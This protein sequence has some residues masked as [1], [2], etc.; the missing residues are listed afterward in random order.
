MDRQ[1]PSKTQPHGSVPKGRARGRSQGFRGLLRFQQPE[2]GQGPPSSS[3]PLSPVSGL[4]PQV[5]AWGLGSPRSEAPPSQVGFPAPQAAPPPGRAW[6]LG[7][8]LS[9]TAPRQMGPPATQTTAPQG[10][11]WG[12][13]SPRTEAAPSQIGAPPTQI[14]APPGRAWG[15]GPQ[16]SETASRQ[17]GAPPTQTTIPQRPAGAAQTTPTLAPSA[18]TTSSGQPPQSISEST[19]SGSSSSGREIETFRSRPAELENKKGTSGKPVNLVANYYAV[20]AKGADRF[21]LYQ[22]HVSFEPNSE[23]QRARNLALRNWCNSL[24]TKIGYIFDGGNAM[25]S[26]VQLNCPISFSHTDPKGKYESSV[27]TIKHVGQ[28][29]PSSHTYIM[30]YN[31]FIRNILKKLQLKCIRRNHFDDT[32]AIN[33]P[34]YGLELWPGLF[35]V[36][37]QHEKSLLLC[38]DTAFKVLRTDSVLAVM[39]RIR[40]NCLERNGSEADV[41]RA[42]KDE[43]VGTIV[44]TCNSKT[45]RIDDIDPQMRPTHT[46][47]MNGTDVAYKQHFLKKYGL[48][49]NNDNQPMLISLPTKWQIRNNRTDNIC[50]IPELCRSTG[51]TDSMRGNFSLMKSLGEHMHAPPSGRVA[52]IEN[53]MSRVQNNPDI[54]EYREEWGLGIEKEMVK[55]PGRI[56]PPE[57]LGFANNQGFGADDNG[58][59]TRAFREK[60]M[61]VSVALKEWVII[62]PRRDMGA[63]DG[64][65]NTLKRVSTPLQFHISD[66]RERKGIDGRRTQ[67][68]SQA[69]HEVM[70]KHRGKL[71]MIFIVLPNNRI[72]NYAAV[73]RACY[74]D[75]GIQSQCFL[76]KNL[77]NRGLMSIATKVAIQMNAKLGG[78]PW[79]VANPMKDA[80]YVGFDVYHS[81]ARNSPSIGAMT[82]T[83]NKNCSRYYSTTSTHATSQELSDNIFNDM[84]KCLLAYKKANG[85]VPSRIIFYRDG[86]GEGQL[87]LVYNQEVVPLKDGLKRLYDKER[88]PEV[89]LTFVVVTKRINTRLFLHKGGKAFDNPRPGTIVDDVIT[90]PE[91]YD[92]FL[93]SQVARQGTVSPTHYNVLYDFQGL[94]PD[95]LQLLTYKLCYGYF[96]WSGTVSVPAPCQYAHKLA[97][98]AGLAVKATIHD[99]LS[100]YL[101]Y[102]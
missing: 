54:R 58:D 94:P 31:R 52:M 92:F 1:D 18:A 82:A 69:I 5:R 85:T 42:W 56:L 22:Y 48:E 57:K 23:I 35:Q 46:F 64:F 37:E 13:P 65:L 72:D 4:L 25:Y 80:M 93:I 77:T 36:I 33:I 100:Q 86:V 81:A 50:L 2:H 99:D 14:A 75:Y 17:I 45:F 29:P 21:I 47:K 8:P 41:L 95:R 28:V 34:T 11:A 91:R 101:Y 90:K 102:L 83:M 6:G 38:V 43:L 16:L 19:P 78:E 98:M 73:K 32:M 74:H 84:M 87:S 3:S 89:K 26:M 53:F 71:G 96:N 55:L 79:G 76:A 63:V 97:Y 60:A 67:E 12:L 49:T 62:V 20:T 44:M 27:V 70:T 40:Q 9:E 10:R 66:P 88:L 61:M 7:P 15:L 39:N 30:F 51:L 24:K 68:F 59:F